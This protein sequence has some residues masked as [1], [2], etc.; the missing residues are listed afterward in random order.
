MHKHPWGH[1][2]RGPYLR[3]F[4]GKKSFLSRSAFVPV[5]A[6]KRRNEHI[7]PRSSNR[8]W[9]AREERRK[10]L[11]MQPQPLE[12]RA[13]NA[14]FGGAILSDARATLREQACCVQATAWCGAGTGRNLFRAFALSPKSAS[15]RSIWA[16][17]A[18][19]VTRM[20]RLSRTSVNPA[21]TIAYVRCRIFFL[22]R[23]VCGTSRAW[24][25]RY[26]TRAV[27]QSE[28]SFPRGGST[29]KGEA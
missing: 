23:K 27:V 8:C 13:T 5:R 7:T 20:S 11:F 4:R 26:R 12:R 28:Q 21:R 19:I 6:W 2:R 15:E 16:T 22:K 3:G 9:Q 10:T 29:A 24:I 14:P 18:F 1:G 25:I 17:G